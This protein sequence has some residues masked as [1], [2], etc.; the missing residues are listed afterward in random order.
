MAMAQTRKKPADDDTTRVNG[1]APA[2][3][4]MTTLDTGATPA[5][6][7][8][9]SEAAA[10]EL[11]WEPLSAPPAAGY[12]DAFAGATMVDT[13]VAAYS[14]YTH[15]TDDP[16][17]GEQ[18]DG[19]PLFEGF[20]AQAMDP[21]IEADNSWARALRRTGRVGVWGLP[22][23][24]IGLALSAL[25]GWPEPG[26]AS[27]N[28]GTWLVLTVAALIFGLLG[29]LSVLA[30]LTATPARGWAVA[31]VVGLVA[32]TLLLAPV[33]GVLGLARP[34][35]T[36]ATARIPT[37]AAALQSDL[38]DGQVARWFVVGG[39]SLLA[40]GLA[41]LGIAVL[42]SEALTR[43]DGYLVLAATA[44]AVVAAWRA[45]PVL[46]VISAMVLLAAALGIAW[47]ASRLTPAGRLPDDA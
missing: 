1:R 11:R 15:Q 14:M 24:A 7:T 21:E 31:S 47:T 28:P 19:S 37:E 33:L 13:S 9:G 20:D 27:A 32:G 26:A 23:A 18:D 3:A 36:N 29:S 6:E 34:A 43:V 17:L 44:L 41:L 10:G 40:V 5:T 25:W 38:I 42:A 2:D 16:P 4:R 45:W 12:D 30:L 35:V 8:P 22:M 39:L 46:L